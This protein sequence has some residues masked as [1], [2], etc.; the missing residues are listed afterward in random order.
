MTET[1]TPA[2]IKAAAR[3]LAPEIE[4]RAGEIAELRRLPADLVLK[5]KASGA[6]RMLMPRAWG[7]PEMT[8]REQT[9]VIEIYSQADAS[10]GWCVMIG[11]DSGFFVGFHEEAAARELYPD[12]D[13]SIAGAGSP[14]GRAVRVPDGFRVSGRWPFASN[15]NNAEV[16]I[17]ICPVFDG[18][19]PVLVQG[20]P[21]MRL[22]AAPA[23]S[24]EILD[25]WY[26]TGLAGSGSND[27]TAKDLFIPESHT[28]AG[29]PASRP[30]RP[31]PIYAWPS[32][33]LANMHGVPLGL[34]RHA[35]D[36]VKTMAGQKRQPNWTR[37]NESLL[38]KEVPRVRASIARAEML[39]GAARAY[40]YET[41]DRLWD[42]LCGEHRVSLETRVA[43]AASRQHAFKIGRE[44]AQ[45]MVDTAGSSAIYRTSPLDRLLRDAITM[46]QHWTAQER[47]LEMIGAVALGDDL[48][49][50]I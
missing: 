12:L 41:L 45:L 35:I 23:A 18:E 25:T 44:I 24:W 14:L 46:C 43:V 10:V 26:T 31:E 11:S 50:M 13:F 4:S 1:M 39:L 27:Y 49:G 20:H 33:F 40:T 7:G 42:E 48:P 19:T 9:E 16:I 34:A 8:P 36:I 3:T 38:M 47:T 32:L 28:I 2:A 5:L 15:I 22:V 21:E 6:F 30:V 37:P 29:F 17:A